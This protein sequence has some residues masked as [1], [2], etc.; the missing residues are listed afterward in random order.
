MI[1]IVH[2]GAKSGVSDDKHCFLNIT[3]LNAIIHADLKL[4]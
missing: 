1:P 3:I 2:T 4:L